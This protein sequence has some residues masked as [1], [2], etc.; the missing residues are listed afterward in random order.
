M[1]SYP[2]PVTLRSF[3]LLVLLLV[4]APATHAMLESSFLY[5]PTHA[6]NQSRLAEWRIDGQLAGYART[7]AQPRSIWLILH[8]NGGQASNRNYIVDCLPADASAYIVEYPG[9]GLRPGKP[10]MTSLNTAA[11]DAYS[12]LRSL[13]PDT[14]LGVFGESLGSGPACFLCSL[15]TPPDRLV[16]AVPFDTLVSVAKEHLP[17]LPVRL[18]MRDKWDNIK[19]L[20]SYRGPVTIFGAQADNIIPAF[21]AQNL[22]RSIPQARYLELPGGHNEWS[23]S[24]LTRISSND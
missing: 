16:L 23:S 11:H 10:S 22:A 7:V 4:A 19:A 21:H 1:R 18:L 24:E 6:A 12:H 2:R 5:F 13:Y 9:Y 14:P 3:I 20:K 17:Y 15:P 8:G